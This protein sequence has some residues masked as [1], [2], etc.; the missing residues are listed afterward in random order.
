MFIQGNAR[1]LQ[2]YQYSFLGLCWY[3]VLLALHWILALPM[4]G[5]FF[6]LTMVASYENSCTFVLRCTEQKGGAGVVCPAVT[7]EWTSPQTPVGPSCSPLKINNPKI[8][9]YLTCELSYS[10]PFHPRVS[11]RTPIDISNLH[12]LSQPTLYFNLH[13]IPSKQTPPQ[14]A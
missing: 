12:L 2:P 3:V 7:Q 13:P 1:P 14:S 6:F 8:P 10:Y 9:A 5:S 4:F 11:V